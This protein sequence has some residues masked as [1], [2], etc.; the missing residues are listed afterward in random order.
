MVIFKWSIPKLTLNVHVA[1]M[2]QDMTKLATYIDGIF[3]KCFEASH[4]NLL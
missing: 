3:L 2:T 1:L 4:L